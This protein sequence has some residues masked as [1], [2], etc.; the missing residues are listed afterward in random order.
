MP[1]PSSR[2]R[3]LDSYENILSERGPVEITLDAVAA[4]AG[5]SKGGLLYHFGSKDA[6]RDGLLDRMTQRTAEDV[7]NARHAPEGVV[8]YFLRTAI[9]DA[10]PKHPLHRTTM[11]TLRLALNDPRATEVMH[12]GTTAY[13]DLL[14]EH[15][16]DPLTAELVLL[17]GD[18]L[19]M[20]S[21][22]GEANTT[23]LLARIGEIA[24]RLNA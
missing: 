20:R 6:L 1:K 5:V 11:A 14:N 9:T 17:V 21:A 12:R 2:E 24:N 4:H 23:T 10:T 3:I 7:D 13:R 18:G 15:I 8:R 16:D 22:L 19:Y